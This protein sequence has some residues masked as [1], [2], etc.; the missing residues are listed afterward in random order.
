MMK[1]KRKLKEA[2]GFEGGMKSQVP[3]N[4]RGQVD[5]MLKKLKT[6]APRH[7]ERNMRDSDEFNTMNTPLTRTPEP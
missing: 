7:D 1:W 6:P 5:K 2:F 3:L 4:R